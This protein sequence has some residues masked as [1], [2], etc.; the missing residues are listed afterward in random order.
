MNLQSLDYDGIIGKTLKIVPE[1]KEPF[2]KENTQWTE[3]K[4][5]PYNLFDIVLMPWVIAILSEKGRDE[6][7][8][9]VFGFFEALAGHPKQDIRDLIGV[10]V[11]ETLVCDEA[12]LQRSV[13]FMGPRLKPS[14]TCS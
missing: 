12:A 4:M 3:E 8:L 9:R 5:G 7:L 13:K 1:I 6:D 2:E 11:C 10:A 14:A